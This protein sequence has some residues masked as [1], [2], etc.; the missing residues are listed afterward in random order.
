MEVK[1]IYELVNSATAQAIGKSDLLQED[2]GN[3]VDVGEAIM[4]ANSLDH[5]VKSLVD[6]IGKV[7]GESYLHLLGFT[8]EH[9]EHPQRTLR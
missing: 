7:V 9:R 4:N 3:L 1:Q 2:L 8:G 6:H 5:Y